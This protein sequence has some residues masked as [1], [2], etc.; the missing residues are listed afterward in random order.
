VIDENTSFKNYIEKMKIRVISSNG[1][2]I[3]VNEHTIVDFQDSMEILIAKRRMITSE[4]SSIKR[5]INKFEIDTSQQETLLK[6]E[7]LLQSFDKNISAFEIDAITVE[8]IVTKLENE[9]AKIKKAITLAT[10]VNNQIVADIY[11]TIKKYAAELEL[12][13][14]MNNR[15]DFIFTDDLKSLSGAILHK[16]VFIFKLAYIKAVQNKL[17]IYLPIILDSPSGRELDKPNIDKLMGILNRDFR[18]N[19]I[20]ISSI[21]T[22][23]FDNIKVFELGESLIDEY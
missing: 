11:E 4:L 10:K 3:P 19:Q 12:E 17:K 21:F 8:K 14:S 7:T 23:T 13:K 22:Y 18:E 5:A 6:T 1:E 9:R 2:E 20:I 16:I 15:Q